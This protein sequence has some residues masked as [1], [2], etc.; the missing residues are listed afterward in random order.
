[1]A[2][3][4][5]ESGTWTDEAARRIAGSIG[6]SLGA[7]LDGDDEGVQAELA[8]ARQVVSNPGSKRK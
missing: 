1:M 8:K 5:N 3:D 6:R 7:L 4:K 2:S